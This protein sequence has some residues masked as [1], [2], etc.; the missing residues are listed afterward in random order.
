VLVAL[1]AY[2]AGSKTSRVDVEETSCLS[3]VGTIS[4]E[5]SDGWTVSVPLEVSWAEPDGTFHS[6][7]RPDCL[8]VKGRGL[9]GPV[10][11]GIR[12]VAMDGR[13]WRQVVWVQCL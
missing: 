8:P 10:Q 7:G 2:L 1:L 13:S 11:L 3:S 4:C 12:P 9:T 5:L 6:D